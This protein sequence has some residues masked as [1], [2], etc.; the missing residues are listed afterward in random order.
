MADDFPGIFT[1]RQIWFD[2]FLGI[3]TWANVAL[4]TWADQLALIP[5]A[6]IAGL[7]TKTMI[8]RRAAL[9]ARVGELGVYALMGIGVLVMVAVLSYTS[10]PQVS[11]QFA[12]VRYLLP[13]LA[14]LGA[15]LALAAR[16]AG[17]RWGPAAG[18]VIVVLMLA[19]D[20]FTQLLFV[21]RYY[22]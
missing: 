9:R 13:M 4:P 2:G 20:I 17:R 5:A 21:S 6:A 7:C 18:A 1:T 15:I 12:R 16:G 14:L 8:E 10:F 3:Y 22:G 11:A 19:H